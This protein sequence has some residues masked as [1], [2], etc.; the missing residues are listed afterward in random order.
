[1]GLVE[2]AME[3]CHADQLDRR[4]FLRV[5]RMNVEEQLVRR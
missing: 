5:H 1:M 4:D 3:K 2:G